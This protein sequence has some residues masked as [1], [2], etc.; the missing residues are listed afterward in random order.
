MQNSSLVVLYE[1]SGVSFEDSKKQKAYET[2]SFDN[3]RAGVDEI[4]VLNSIFYSVTAWLT[5]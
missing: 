4:K 3:I 2:I 5:F 1:A